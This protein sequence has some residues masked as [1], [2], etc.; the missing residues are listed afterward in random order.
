[1]NK[2]VRVDYLNV[3]YGQGFVVE[4]N[5]SSSLLTDLLVTLILGTVA[6]DAGLILGGVIGTLNA[7]IVTMDLILQLHFM[8]NHCAR[9]SLFLCILF[10]LSILSFPTHQ[11]SP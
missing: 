9:S 4:V 8:L 11:S 2:Y 7:H 3:V 10:L 5:I 1:V 6:G